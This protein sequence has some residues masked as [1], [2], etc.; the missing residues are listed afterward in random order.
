M[1]TEKSLT[2]DM[3]GLIIKAKGA[4]LRTYEITY[5]RSGSPG[6]LSGL[7]EELI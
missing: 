3:G 7:K 4:R 6:D 5:I 2:Y 1:P